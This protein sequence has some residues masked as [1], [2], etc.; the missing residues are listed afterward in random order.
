[1]PSGHPNRTVNRVWKSQAGGRH[2]RLHK[3]GVGAARALAIATHAEESEDEEAWKT[4]EDADRERLALGV[5]GRCHPG[6]GV[7][8]IRLRRI[9][10][11]PDR[12]SR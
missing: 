1:M 3:K 9:D 7:R 11:H 5:S 8:A 12:G 4:D 10:D 2:S 6:H